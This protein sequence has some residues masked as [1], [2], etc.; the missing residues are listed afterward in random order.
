MRITPLAVHEQTFRM[1]FRGFDPVEVDG[2][3]QRVADELE[4]LTEEREA[5]RTQLDEEK[6]VRKALEDSLSTAQTLQ[7]GILARAKEEADLLR[8]QAQVRADRILAE[9]N[10]ELLRLRRDLEALRDRRSLWLAEIRALSR[11]LEEWAAE[12]EGEQVVPPELIADP[13]GGEPEAHEAAEDVPADGVE[14][15]PPEPD[16]A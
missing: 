15:A 1:T 3:L 2:F 16:A 7:D 9:A 12:K 8:T 6:Q 4:R 5:L 11:T 10:E 13:G 14:P